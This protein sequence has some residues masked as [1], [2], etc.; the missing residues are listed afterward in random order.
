MEK[1]TQIKPYCILIWK[2]E[3]WYLPFEMSHKTPKAGKGQ[4]VCVA[5]FKADQSG[6]IGPPNSYTLLLEKHRP[7]QV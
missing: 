2:T 1:N 7:A 5:F 4:Q 6:D 3:P